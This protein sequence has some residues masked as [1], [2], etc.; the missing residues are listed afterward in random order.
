[1]NLVTPVTRMIRPDMALYPSKI[2]RLIDRPFRYR[3]PCDVPG[4]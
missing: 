4:R 1:M 3:L 2:D